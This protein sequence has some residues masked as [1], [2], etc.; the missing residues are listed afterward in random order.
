MQQ[1]SDDILTSNYEL[2]AMSE[3]DRKNR[4]QCHIHLN[5]GEKIPCVSGQQ[6]QELHT[7]SHKILSALHI[8]LLLK[9]SARE[10]C[11]QRW[12]QQ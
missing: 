1:L 8:K 7:I 4:C 12:S 10:A 6:S 5:T 11:H 9:L 3:V 2:A